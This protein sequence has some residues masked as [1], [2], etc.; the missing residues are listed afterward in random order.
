MDIKR[1]KK[2]PLEKILLS[3]FNYILKAILI[4]CTAKVKK[5]CFILTALKL[6]VESCLK[7]GV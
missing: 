1:L 2:M 5:I 6:L 7:R 3:E 4:K